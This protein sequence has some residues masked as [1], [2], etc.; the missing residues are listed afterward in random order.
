M[1]LTDDSAPRFQNHVAFDNLPLGD[2]TKSNTP[3]F[4][5]NVRHSG[6]QAKRRSRTFMV[7]VDEHAYS[8]YALQW[9]LDELVD[10]GDEVVC[11]RVIEREPRAFEKEKDNKD[12]SKVYKDDAQ[13]LMDAIIEK[14]GANRAISV[15]LEYA[16]GKLHSTFQ[17]LVRP[18]IAAAVAPHRRKRRPTDMP[19]LPRSK[20]TNPR[21]S[22]SARAADP[23]AACKAWLTPE[24]PSP[25]TAS[26]TRPSPSWW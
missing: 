13:K 3:S 15:I 9:L 4:T 24:T 21:C 25:S 23:S 16:A 18:S 12:A 20:Y 2:A 7:G 11:V 10:D 1:A 8:D 26:S 6:Y 17:K 5:L 22:S 19:A 14:N